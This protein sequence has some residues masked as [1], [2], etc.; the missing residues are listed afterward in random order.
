MLNNIIKYYEKLTDDALVNLKNEKKMNIKSRLTNRN[1]IMQSEDHLI[2][3]YKKAGGTNIANIRQELEKYKNDIKN[4]HVMAVKNYNN[5]LVSL[6]NAS[7]VE[8]KQKILNRLADKGLQGFKAKNGA[9]WN[10]ETYSNMYFTHL[11]NEMVRRGQYDY[12]KSKGKNKVQISSH[13]NSCPVCEPYQGLI[14]TFEELEEAK[15]AGLFHVRCKHFFIEVQ[16]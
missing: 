5:V 7:N 15:K 1:L 13:M 6:K 16:E 4:M 2:K 12:I 11:N 9:I 14:L 8:E 3:M 10:I